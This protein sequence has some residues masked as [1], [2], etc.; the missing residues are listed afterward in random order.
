MTTS[1]C[2]NMQTEEQKDIAGVHFYC[3]LCTSGEKN[4]ASVAFSHPTHTFL[5]VTCV[6]ILTFSQLCHN[7]NKFII[8]P[9]SRHLFCRF[10]ETDIELK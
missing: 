9:S 10:T 5:L 2:T 4:D 6:T 1:F 3:N 8:R 7:Y